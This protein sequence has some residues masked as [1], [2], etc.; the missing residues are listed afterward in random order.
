MVDLA[1]FVKR[2]TGML[3]RPLATMREHADPLPPWQVVAREHVLPLVAISA[4]VSTLLFWVMLAMSGMAF[5]PVQL[6]MQ[7]VLTMVIGVVSVMITGAVV[8]VFSGIFGGLQSFNGGMVLAGLAMTPQYLAEALWPVPQIGILLVIA[9]A[10]ASLVLI[11]RGAPVVLR[12]PAENR[13]KHFAMSIITLLLIAMVVGAVF[14]D[15]VALTPLGAVPSPQ[16]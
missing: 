12:L 5:G 13:G 3:R 14:V 11:Y 15:V 1:L 8:S 16:P 4:L 10:I 6:V 2:C 9:G 7:F